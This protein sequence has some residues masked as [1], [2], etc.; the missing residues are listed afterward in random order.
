LD[1]ADVANDTSNGDHDRL[2]FLAIPTSFQPRS[3]I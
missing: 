1:R 3:L 2:R